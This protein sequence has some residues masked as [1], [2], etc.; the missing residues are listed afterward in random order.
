VTSVISATAIAIALFGAF[1]VGGVAG[2]GGEGHAVGKRPQRTHAEAA[3]RRATPEPAE[4]ARSRAAWRRWAEVTEAV[5]GSVGAAGF[6]HPVT[7][8][9]SYGEAGAGFGAHR[10]GHVHEGQDVF[11]PPGTPLVAVS[12]GTV[13]EAG[14]DGDRGNHLSIYSESTDETYLYFHMLRPAEV[15]AG[16]RVGVGQQ[17][18]ELGCTGSCYGEHL[19]F[20]IHVGE[21]P[22]GRAVDP[23]PRLER[24]PS[25]QPAG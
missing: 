14:S 24:W 25:A 21:G 1:A 13:V 5:E 3:I 7:G 9:V 16:E 19:H 12:D 22:E 15:E 6:Q 8:A 18:G 23:L 17:V 10:S 4:Q 2:A 11:A 20:E